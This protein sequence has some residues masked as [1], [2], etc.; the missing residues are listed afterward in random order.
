MLFREIQSTENTVCKSPGQRGSFRQERRPGVDRF[1]R[2]S[3]HCQKLRDKSQTR[4]DYKSRNLLPDKQGVCQS[5]VWV[6]FVITVQPGHRDIQPPNKYMRDRFSI[7]FP[8]SACHFSDDKM[9][10]MFYSASSMKEYEASR[11]RGRGEGESIF[12]SLNKSAEREERERKER[13]SRISHVRLCGYV[14]CP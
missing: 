11:K 14:V 5:E 8:F 12:I 13:R 2:V 10:D 9:S 4:E 7:S 6:I 1:A 3:A